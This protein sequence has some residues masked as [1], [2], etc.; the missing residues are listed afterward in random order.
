MCVCV[1][2][3]VFVCVGMCAHVVVRMRNCIVI[4][5]FGISLRVQALQLLSV[6]RAIVCGLMEKIVNGY[7]VV[8]TTLT[9]GITYDILKSALLIVCLK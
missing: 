9:P 8:S 3:H 6:R 7:L 1:C 5:L 2:V 4:V